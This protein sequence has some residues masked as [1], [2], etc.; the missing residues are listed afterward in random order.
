MDIQS[1][2][3]SPRATKR[4]AAILALTIAAAAGLGGCVAPDGSTGAQ[5][6]GDGPGTRDQVSPR[7]ERL[8]IR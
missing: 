5:I 6:T 3:K 8:P 1:V 4:V 2:A 7:R